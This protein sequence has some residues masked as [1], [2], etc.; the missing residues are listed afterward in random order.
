MKKEIELNRVLIHENLV[1]FKGV[2]ETKNSVNLI[3]ENLAG[4]PIANRKKPGEIAKITKIQK[5]IF[6]VLKG[7]DYLEKRGI[8]HR[9]IKMRN[10]LFTDKSK[11]FVKIIDFGLGTEEQPNGSRV[12]G[13]PGYIDP[14]LF[15]LGCNERGR[16]VN[17]KND[18]FSLGVVFHFYLFGELLYKGEARKEILDNNKIGE[19]LLKRRDEMITDVKCERA[20]DLLRMMTQPKQEDRVSVEEA[21]NH[22]FF[23]FLEDDEEV[24]VDDEEGGEEVMIEGEEE[25]VPEDPVAGEV[26]AKYGY[27]EKKFMRRLKKVRSLES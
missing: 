15:T 9:D 20:W 16:L 26:M 21:L 22:S 14:E 13:S 19:F 23:E 10:L 18:V 17:S 1:E 3:F 8:V 25:D 12:A 5:I 6:Q 24:M 27:R 2:Y 7:L 4:G 11:K